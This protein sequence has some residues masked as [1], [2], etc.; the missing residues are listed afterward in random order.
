[1]K[2]I[3]EYVDSVTFSQELNEG[4]GQSVYKITGIF[5]TIGEK[6]KNGR[7]YPASIWE[8]EIKAYQ[9]VLANGSSNTL[10]EL[11][12]PPR[13]NVEMMEAVAKINKL[14][15]DGK[16]VMGEAILLNN[17]RAN[18][19]KS[20]IDAGVKMSVSSRGVGKV[21]ATGVVENFKLSTY[22]I[23]PDQGQSDYNAQMM[24]I[25]EGVLQ[26]KEFEILADGCVG[27]CELPTVTEDVNEEFT[28]VTDLKAILEKIGAEV[29]CDLSKEDKEKV[30]KEFREGDI[31]EKNI[32]NKKQAL[33]FLK[34]IRSAKTLDDLE[35]DFGLMVNM[36]ESEIDDTD[37]KAKYDSLL[38]DIAKYEAYTEEEFAKLQPKEVVEAKDPEVV[39]T[40]EEKQAEIREA[41]SLKLK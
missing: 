28:N 7:V 36:V 12:H 9:D 2:L 16:Y 13:A 3:Y 4:T 6:N 37:Y 39:K 23:I 25:V 41:F 5:S 11:N 34:Q 24:G 20:L 31:T 27:E 35:D 8:R 26:D 30:L 33:W 17:P 18:Q 29:L 1:M 21:S 14:Y 38:E 19:L 15:I 22:D 10:M 40:I 32:I